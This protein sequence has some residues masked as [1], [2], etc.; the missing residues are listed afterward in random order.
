MADPKEK[1]D[2]AT[3]PDTGKTQ[4]FTQKPG[5]MDYAKEAFLPS[6]QRAQLEAVRNARA[7][8]TGS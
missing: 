8:A 6:M 1:K 7:K 3:D 2:Y 4:A 5:V